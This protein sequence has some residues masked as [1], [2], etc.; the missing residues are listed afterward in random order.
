MK[1]Y[2]NDGVHTLNKSNNAFAV[3]CV[4]YKIFGLQKRKKGKDEM[5][6]FVLIQ[7]E[8]S[9]YGFKKLFR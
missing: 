4:E 2:H 7:F 8:W 3:M 6:T 9:I 1:V 5:I